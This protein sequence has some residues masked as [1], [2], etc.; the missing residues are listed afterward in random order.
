M[1][2]NSWEN[3]KNNKKII[4]L[5]ELEHILCWNILM[6]GEHKIHPER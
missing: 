1:S 4:F 2:F 5:K 3:K 6:H